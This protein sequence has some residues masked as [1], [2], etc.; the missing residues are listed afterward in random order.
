MYKCIYTG[1]E[2]ETASEEHILQNFFG[3]RW[4]DGTI[5]CDEKQ[6]Q[7]GETIDLAL[8][9]Q[10]QPIK[11]LLGHEGGRG[12]YSQ[13]LKNMQ[14]K[15]GKIYHIEPGGKPVI[16]KPI[17]TEK[18]INDSQIQV[19][20]TGSP[21]QLNWLIHELKKK[22][23]EYNF[24]EEEIKKCISQTSSYLTQPVDIPLTLGGD[25]FFRA[26]C[27]A[28]FNLLGVKQP[29]IIHSNE[30]D[31]V[32]KFISEGKGNHH[33]F[34]KWCSDTTPL[35][36]ANL[37]PFDHF[38]C[39]FSN[40]GIIQSFVQL[41]GSILFLLDFGR[42]S[43]TVDFKH[44]YVVNPYRDTEPN[45]IRDMKSF[46]PSKIL[47]FKWSKDVNDDVIKTLL[48]RFNQ[49]FLPSYSEKARKKEMRSILKNSFVKKEYGEV[50]IDEDLEKICDDLMPFVMSQLRLQS[51]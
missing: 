18:K 17:L 43:D 41:Y 7:F 28:S 29:S 19:S 48:A 3:A 9:N 25:D 23:P 39:V 6:R 14:S 32:R 35:E 51:D 10:L 21:K 44:S 22:Y 5:V 16:A 49:V 30:L 46:D 1:K 36:I 40:E 42:M 27:K 34:V 31:D 15:D 12:G 37:S 13:P 50:K 47:G 24:N 38:L 11:T 33:S 20:A 2:F 26:I 4:K 45:E 8:A